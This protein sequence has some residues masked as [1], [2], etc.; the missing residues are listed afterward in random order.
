MYSP[1]RLYALFVDYVACM[2]TVLK[3]TMVTRRAQPPTLNLLSILAP[4]LALTLALKL[5]STLAPI[6]TSRG[7][8]RRDQFS[9]R[10]RQPRRRADRPCDALSPGRWDA[11]GDYG[12]FWHLGT[13]PTHRNLHLQLHFAFTLHL[14]LD[15]IYICQDSLQL[16]PISAFHLPHSLPPARPPTHPPTIMRAGAYLGGSEPRN[17]S[18]HR[19]QRGHVM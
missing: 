6:L 11:V 8:E 2:A 15:Y 4:A 19:R 9:R 12:V 1:I 7:A 10:R 3:T 5:T 16:P 14:H 17:G 18:H 13:A